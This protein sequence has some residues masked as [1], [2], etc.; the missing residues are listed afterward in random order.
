MECRGPDGSDRAGYGH[1]RHSP[2]LQEPSPARWLYGP[3][4]LG[5]D[6]QPKAARSAFEYP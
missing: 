6:A 4:Y 5:R 1:E 2:A 3:E